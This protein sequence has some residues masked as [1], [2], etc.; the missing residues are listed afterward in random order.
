VLASKRNSAIALVNIGR[1][2]YL[3]GSL[4]E[5]IPLME[6]AIRLSP[7]DPF[8]GAWCSSIAM[9]HLLQSHTDEAILWYETAR[10]ADPGRPAVHAG[11][12]AARALK[13]ETE[14][15]TTELS[16]ARRLVG[17]DRYS[18]LAQFKALAGGNL[19][20]PKV[21][22]LFEATYFVGLRKAGMPEE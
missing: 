13:G 22:A 9:V 14:S 21:R 19:G 6:Q 18:N 15:A 11:L 2:R 7:R 20:V 12:A 17:D 3:T 4:D 8:I 10:I 1:C 5:A 16:D